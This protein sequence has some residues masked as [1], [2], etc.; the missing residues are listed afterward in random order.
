MSDFCQL[1]LR[2]KDIIMGNVT[3]PNPSTNSIENYGCY[4]CS[5]VS[6]LSDRGY[7]WDPASFNLLLRANGA[8][9]GPYEDYIDS[10]NLPKY[11]PDVFISYQR[12]DPWNDI[13]KVDNLV[14]ESQIVVCRVNARAIGG[15]GTHYLLLKGQNKGV[16][17]IF[18]PWTNRIEPITTTYGNYGDILGID[19]FGVKTKST[20]PPTPTVQSAPTVEPAPEP[21][22][23]PSVPVTTPVEPPVTAPSTH[24]TPDT[25]QTTTYPLDVVITPQIP[26]VQVTDTN[27]VIS[28]PT[29]IQL[30]VAWLKSLLG[31]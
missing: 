29:I 18:D 19:V 10:A 20:P 2:W 4:L 5:L 11:M 16:A 17:L 1:D 6:G 27:T 28:K 12:I 13:P 7:G 9:V 30:I 3:G 23:S 8:W 26:S 31:Q 15:T 21:L 14:G 24:T 22:A 25:T